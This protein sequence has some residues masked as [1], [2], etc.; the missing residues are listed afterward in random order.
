MGGRGGRSGSGARAGSSGAVRESEMRGGRVYKTR[1]N[2][3]AT[4]GPNTKSSDVM[5]TIAKG[6]FRDVGMGT[7]ALGVNVK[8]PNVP[9]RLIIGFSS[10]VTIFSPS[11]PSS[12]KWSFSGREYGS[13]ESAESAARSYLATEYRN[14]AAYPIKNGDDYRTR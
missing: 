9:G 4:L 5:A 6:Q 8:T 11:H 7:Y 12:G 14:S 1:S 2:G 3:V 10:E 13:R